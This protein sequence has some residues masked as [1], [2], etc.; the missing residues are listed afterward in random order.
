MA[1]VRESRL[2]LAGFS[3][4]ML[5]LPGAGRSPLLLLHGFSDSA[6]TWRTVMAR[7]G[8]RGLGAT[9]L[10][11]PGFGEAGRLARD[12]PILPQLDRFAHAAI[13]HLASE[14]GAD[15]VVAGNSLGGCVALRAAQRENNPIAA[16]V[17]IAPAG[18]DLAGWISI[19]EGAWAVQTVLRS[20]LP[21]PEVAVRELLGR[22][23]RQ[24]AS[25]HPG[26]VD[27]EVVANFTRHV[28]SKRDVVRL[29]GI[30]RRLR[31]EIADP[32]QLGWIRCPV[33]V[34]WGEKDRMVSPA[35]AQ[36]ILDEVPHATLEL[37]PDCGHCPQVECSDL[38]ADTLAGVL[39]EVSSAAA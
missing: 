17:P 39:S 30:A 10:D 34:I 19:V 9:A 6:D 23:Y 5:E 3:T 32:F 4:R 26:Q 36:R 11:L 12:Q 31:P 24:L 27:P 14:S 20:P 33:S 7:L 18:L 16:I 37:L 35:G 21:L 38:V 28:R 29:L 13:N 25:A 1:Q 22:A 2:E 8:D 15:V